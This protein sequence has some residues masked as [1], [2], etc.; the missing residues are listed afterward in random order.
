MK[1][2]K[3]ITIL[4]MLL[5]ATVGCE[6]TFETKNVEISLNRE[7]IRDF[8]EEYAIERISGDITYKAKKEIALQEDRRYIY[9]DPGDYCP[10]EDEY[11]TVKFFNIDSIGD[12]QDYLITSYENGGFKLAVKSSAHEDDTYFKR[13][14]YKSITFVHPLYMPHDSI[15]CTDL[16]Y[17][18][19]EYGIGLDEYASR[20]CSGKIKVY[21][22]NGDETCLSK[23]M[24]EASNEK[25]VWKEYY[26]N[27]NVKS[28]KTIVANPED[29]DENGFAAKPFVTNT[30]YYFEDGTKKT[31]ESVM[32]K[33]HGNYA[34]FAS[35]YRRDGKRIWAVFL[36]D[37]QMVVFVNS[38]NI[39][40]QLVAELRYNYEIRDNKLRFYNGWERYG[41]VNVKHY[42]ETSAEI[43]LN[44]DG[45]SF[46]NMKK[47][48]NRNIHMSA[49]LRK[50]YLPSELLNFVKKYAHT[51]LRGE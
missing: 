46:K 15:V 31:I 12:K 28:I 36:K 21:R 42:P 13:Y 50:D 37:E 26:A 41:I 2:L 8:L 18:G 3:K 40:Q 16:R 10:D 30:E 22:V 1:T 34:L 17:E 29:V 48:G 45:V 49:T 5:T 19:Y 44:E 4:M 7:L 11:E 14:L 51:T 39:H 20:P 27:G 47:Y 6:R 23:E 9:G 25:T 38:R 43:Y 33:Q 24:V 35:D 32:Y